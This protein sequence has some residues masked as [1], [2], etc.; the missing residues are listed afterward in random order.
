MSA[1]NSVSD[2]GTL[3]SAAPL[4]AP[5]LPRA[6]SVAADL[7]HQAAH[8]LSHGAPATAAICQ[9]MVALAAGPSHCG[10]TLAHWP[11]SIMGDAVALR[12][13][14]G[15]HHLWRQGSAPELAPVYLSQLTDQA[16]ID[17]LVAAVV[18]RHDTDLLRWF[19]SPP[20]TN[21]AGRSAAFVAALHWAAAHGLAAPPGNGGARFELL[22]IGASAGMNL[23]IDR[24]RYDLGGVT[25]GPADSPLTIQPEWLGPPPPDAP[26]TIGSVRG[27][28]ISPVDVRDPAALDRLA[29]YCWPDAPHRFARLAAGAAMIR[30]RPVALDAADAADW[31]DAALARPQADGTARVLMHSI[32][33][34]YLPERSQR[35]ITAAMARAGAGAT[36]DRPL[37]WVGLE[38][39]RATMRHNLTVRAWPGL[40]QAQLLAEAHAHG[41][42]IAW[43]GRAPGA[44]QDAGCS[45]AMARRVASA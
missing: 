5:D 33:W 9:A 37:I 34:Q 11:G 1:P 20:Q 45:A 41:A 2:A 12:L 15:L 36:P 10:Q 14:A 22:E 32:V 18:A 29:A 4:P 40:A 3:G 25:S 6:Q 21:E 17:A 26:F 31:T 19:A 35:R 39:D 23:L 24:W 16:S 30:A 13:A 44:D 42:W 28:D 43:L 27:C 8:C 7:T 38:T